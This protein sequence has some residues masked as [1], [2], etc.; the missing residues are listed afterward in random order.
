MDLSGSVAVQTHHNLKP[1]RKKLQKNPRGI[2]GFFSS[3]RWSHEPPPRLSLDAPIQGATTST[4]T[5][6]TSPHQP[7]PVKPRCVS[8]AP[9]LSDAK[10]LAYLDR[11]SLMSTSEVQPRPIEPKIDDRPPVIP[12]L[13][14][15][16]PKEPS[17]RPSLESSPT[18]SLSAVSS[19]RRQAKT[20]VF[21]IGQLE[22]SARRRQARRAN[23]GTSSAEDIAQQYRELLESRGHEDAEIGHT[24]SRPVPMPLPVTSLNTILKQHDGHNLNQPQ[25][26]RSPI[27]QHP[28]QVSP[29][30]SVTT[31]DDGTLVAYQEDAI[32]FKPV[33][34]SPEPSPL[35]Q[36]ESAEPS[37][38]PSA[39][40]SR[41]NLSLDIS[42][43]LLARQLSSAL[44]T[45][46]RTQASRDASALQ[47]W[48]MIEAY[49]RLQEQLWGMNL[50]E[51]ELRSATGALRNWL[52]ALY[53][54][55]RSLTG[56]GERSES[57]YGDIEDVE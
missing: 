17:P 48:V 11:A 43:S 7:T 37:I 50:A 39:S 10:W 21:S 14:H 44:P 6:T 27:S 45:E 13:A 15:L 22:E 53:A 40:A 2:K 3:K 33:S 46:H 55:H 54:V 51:N 29:T 25:A 41:E 34:F 24:S 9:D 38:P 30:T 52:T 47:V 5:S 18:S 12:E 19:L 42:L 32:Y 4:A 35:P 16:V 8:M 23:N 26:R 49:E 31:S 36:N 1:A 28:P 20:P 56:D 57:E